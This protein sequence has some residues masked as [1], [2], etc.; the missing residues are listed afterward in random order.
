MKF[1]IISNV[2]DA[3]VREFEAPDGYTAPPHKFG[4][5]KSERAV[6]VV[7]L[8]PPTLSAGQ[9]L[10]RAEEVTETELRRGWVAVAAPVPAVVSLRQ[11]LM[12]ADR[13]GLLAILETLKTNEALPAQTR[14]DI[15]FF[16]EYSNFIERDHPL[17][18]SLA[19]MLKVTSKQIDQIFQLADTL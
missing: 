9:V 11:F 10:Q 15:H 4:A 5:N 1:A 19:P 8:D 14:R 13:S 6:L 16:L 12:A 3:V 2:T 17:I 7:E 18:A